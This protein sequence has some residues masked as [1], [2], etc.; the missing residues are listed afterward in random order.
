MALYPTKPLFSP[1][2]TATNGS[3]TIQVTGNVNCSFLMAG[4]IVSIAGANRLADAISGTGV[5]S[6]NSTIKL[7][8]P[9]AGA[10]VTGQ[11]IVFMS[12]EGLA[13][14][15]FQLKSI[16]D[17]AAASAD[18]G[19]GYLGNYDLAATGALPPAPADGTGSRMYRIST[20]ATVASVAYR[21]GEVIYFDQYLNAWR[22]MNEALGSGAY[23]NVMTSL[24]DTTTP[25]A[26]MP[27]GAFGCGGQPPTVTSW[28]TS[29]GT[30]FVFAIESLPHAPAGATGTYVI[31]VSRENHYTLRQNGTQINR[32]YFTG[33]FPTQ[34]PTDASFWIRHYHNGNIV[35]IVAQVG[36]IPTG[37][38]IQR[39]GN[40]NGQFTR[41]ADGTQDCW[42]IVAAGVA[43]NISFGAI[44]RTSSVPWTYPIAFVDGNVSFHA[45][46]YSGVGLCW[47]GLGSSGVSATTASYCG[48]S[49]VTSP[50]NMIFSLFAK[51]RWFN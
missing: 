28:P 10:T 42:S 29:V 3:D 51:G 24:T 9:W 37:A 47:A 34:M 14:A 31:E 8:R 43:P 45:N 50:L 44:F 7:A 35:G 40:A 12:Y 16:I 11:M 26:L 17:Q 6:G 2:A 5:V 33:V 49:A 27:R 38:I 48:F 46:E 39:G 19:M 22:R 25:D 15:V 30:Y 4:A 23:A 32:A 1:S 21:A 20:A 13:D 18:I 36:G 41:F